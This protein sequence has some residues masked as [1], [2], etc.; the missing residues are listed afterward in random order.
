MDK[1]KLSVL[2]QWHGT[3]VAFVF[4]NQAVQGLIPLTASKIEPSKSLFKN[5]TLRN[6]NGEKS[7]G[8]QQ[9]QIDR[10]PRNLP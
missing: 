9:K 5:R 10:V 2:V 1:N 6:M 3:E 4:P 7:Q 8:K